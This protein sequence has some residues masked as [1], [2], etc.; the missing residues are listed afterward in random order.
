M[1]YSV[2]HLYK[3]ALPKTN[4]GDCGVPTCL[5]FA[6]KVILDKAPVSGC[7][8]VP[9]D[10]AAE[11][12]RRID[13][14]Q[15][16]GEGTVPDMAADAM[17][18]ARERATSMRLQDLPARIGGTLERRAPGQAVVRLPYFDTEVLV[19]GDP[20]ERVE[21]ADGRELNRW[22]QVLLFNHLAQGGH[23]EP[24]GTWIGLGELPSSTSKVVS[25]R[26]E[27]ERPL[28]TTFDG[29]IDDLRARAT[30]LG[31]RDAGDDLPSADVALVFCPLPR[32]PV[33]LLFWDGDA[34]E[35]FEA[36]VKLLFD[37]TVNEHLDIESIVFLGEQLRARLEA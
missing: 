22:E 12:Q 6:S 11:I 4:C 32:I 10:Q 33:A 17:Q 9:A 31:G 8:H 34:D 18:W 26:D 2:I 37:A 5:A 20:M 7:P 1:T 14:Q 16:R 24:T 21:R 15:S 25:L 28:A 30:A 23:R 19:C 3:E 29:R 13:A 35:G 36:R 27:V